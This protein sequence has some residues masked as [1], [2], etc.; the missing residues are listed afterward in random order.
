MLDETKI[1]VISDLSRASGLASG[2]HLALITMKKYNKK[3]LID[4]MN[5]I[6]QLINKSLQEIEK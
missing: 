5:E 4:V 6:R 2:T 1:K 3:C